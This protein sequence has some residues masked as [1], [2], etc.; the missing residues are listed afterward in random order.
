MWTMKEH[1]IGEEQRPT[2]YWTVT[3]DTGEWFDVPE[4][5]A[6]QIVDA[7]NSQNGQAQAR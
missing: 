2:G 7:I 4:H 5:I 6:R 1:C 3:T